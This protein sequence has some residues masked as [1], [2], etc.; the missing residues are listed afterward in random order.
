MGA[1]MST[2]S[3]KYWK[4]FGWL[5]DIAA[6]LASQRTNMIGA[7]ECNIYMISFQPYTLDPWFLFRFSLFTSLS[8]VNR[9][10]SIFVLHFV[11]SSQCIVCFQFSEL[12]CIWVGRLLCVNLFIFSAISMRF[13][14]YWIWT[15]KQPVESPMEYVC[16]CVIRNIWTMEHYKKYKSTQNLFYSVLWMH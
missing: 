13:F 3:R 5:C 4:C 12:F 10:S 2:K 1:T 11:S 16:F 8:T 6:V 14:L 9:F 7:I 15:T